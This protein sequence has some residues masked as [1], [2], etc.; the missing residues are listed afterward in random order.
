MFITPVDHE[1]NLFQV[2]H[3]VS[4]DLMQQIQRT[5]WLSQ[6]WIPQEGQESWSR[7]RL[8]N[9]NLSWIDQWDK[10]LSSRWNLIETAVGRPL[11]PYAGTAWWVDEP[12]FTCTMHTDGEM[13][14][15]LHLVW[16]GPGTAFYWYKKETTL[17]WQT[18]ATAN[19]G[20]I[21]IN[22]PEP[23]GSRK[24]LWHAMLTPSNDYRV[25][26]YSWITPQ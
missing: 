6:P 13:P 24:L 8:I 11:Q 3:A 5:D 4:V 20:Y 2:Q 9:Q 19:A 1:P 17:R 23:D 7:R 26:S 21:M 18:P 15:S 16:Q 22:Q 10:E 14:G 25:T 12:G